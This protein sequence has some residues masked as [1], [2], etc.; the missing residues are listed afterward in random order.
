MELC[1]HW[2]NTPVQHQSRSVNSSN[3]NA[4]ISA[5]GRYLEIKRVTSLSKVTTNLM[6]IEFAAE[7]ITSVLELRSNESEFKRRKHSLEEF[8][9]SCRCSHCCNWFKWV[10]TVCRFTWK[11]CSIGTIDSAALSDFARGFQSLFQNYVCCSDNNFTT[12]IIIFW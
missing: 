11:H 9:R 12:V 5:F 3:V 1:Q 6:S 8:E 7:A 4:K 10:F 2:D